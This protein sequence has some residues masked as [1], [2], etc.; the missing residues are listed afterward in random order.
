MDLLE[1][2]KIVNTHGL[3]GEV[4]VFPTTDDPERFLDLEYVFLTQRAAR[5]GRKCEAN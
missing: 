1:V 3:K 4:K 5:A 2:G